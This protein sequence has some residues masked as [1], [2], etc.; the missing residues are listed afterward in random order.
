MVLMYDLTDSRCDRFTWNQKRRCRWQLSVVGT[1]AARPLLVQ[2][3]NV[4][5]TN[6]SALLVI[7]AA[8]THKN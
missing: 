1:P 5:Q 4:A 8:P 7:M 3:G 6:L 2:F